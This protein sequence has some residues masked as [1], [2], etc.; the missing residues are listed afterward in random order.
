M[1]TINVRAIKANCFLVEDLN[2]VYLFDYS[3]DI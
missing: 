1:G 3:D 2:R